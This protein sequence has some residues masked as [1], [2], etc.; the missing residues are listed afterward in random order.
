MSTSNQRRLRM[1]ARPSL[2]GFAR[3]LVITLAATFTQTSAAD[4]VALVSSR[5]AMRDCKIQ[6]IQNAQVFYVDPA[7]QRQKR[8]VEEVWTLSFEGLTALDEAE[9]AIADRDYDAARKRLLEALIATD[10]SMQ[11]LWIRHRLNRVHDLRN[12]YAAACA[13]LAE[14]FVLDPDP[15][16]ARLEPRSDAVMASTTYAAAGEA[17]DALARADRAVKVEAIQQSIDSMTAK[18]APIHAELEKSYTG[19]PITPGSTISG[20]PKSQIGNWD[21][22][23][24]APPAHAEKPIERPAPPSTNKKHRSP[25]EPVKRAREPAPATPSPTEAPPGPESPEAIAS[26]LREQRFAEAVELCERVATKLDHRD[27]A[28]FLFQ[29]GEALR[30]TGQPRDAAV[31]YM[32]AAV[33]FPASPHAG[34]SLIET[35]ILYR[36]T[37]KRPE[38]ARRLLERVMQDAERAERPDVADRARTLLQSLD[39]AS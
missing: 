14:V 5:I 16:W 22:T 9:K 1:R 13:H 12:E 27:L 25:D 15:Y 23:N 8:A 20:V 36:D 29:Y 21:T 2:G 38:T 37:F 26:F 39:S 30:H 10:S 34:P 35:A 7:G 4:S 19:P 32:R 6:A 28:E 3:L 31:M 17:I 18:L 11:Q 24:E 33:L